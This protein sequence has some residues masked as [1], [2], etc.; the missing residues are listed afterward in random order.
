MPG[1]LPMN[2]VRAIVEH[3]DRHASYSEINR[4]TGASKG[5]ISK[6]AAAVEAASLT[7]EK[8]LLLNDEDIQNRITPG[9]P[10]RQ[11]EPDWALI[12]GQMHSNRHLTLQLMW[13]AHRQSAGDAAYS[14]PSFCR[15]YASWRKDNAPAEG[16]TNLVHAPADV[17]EIDFAGD[18]LL[19]VDSY[20]EMHK[21]RV[22]VA[23]LPYSG[24]IFAQVFEDEKQHSWI[25]GIAEALT[26]FGG[27]PNALLMDNAR[28]LVSRVDKVAGI[29]QPGIEAECGYYGMKPDNCRIH[30]PRDKNRVEA[31][32][33]FVERWI[34]GALEMTGNGAVLAGSRDCLKSMFRK[35]LDECNDRPWT[36]PGRRGSRRSDF[37]EKERPF[38][39]PLPP[40][41]YRMGEWKVYTVDKGHCVRLGRKDGGHRYSVPAAYAGKKVHVLLS[42][43]FVEIFAFETNELIARHVRR[44]DDSIRTHILEEHL[45]PEE[46]ASRRKPEDWINS[47]QQG[48]ISEA[49]ARKFVMSSVRQHGAFPTNR[50]CAAVHRLRKLYPPSVIE[51]GMARLNDA[52][53]WKARILK[54]VCDKIELENRT[55][56]GTQQNGETGSCETTRHENIRNDYE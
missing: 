42:E 43:Q 3:L 52:G 6:V 13:E 44:R 19:W 49:I 16:Y 26:Y 27:V 47:F 12:A 45:T 20:G 48:G 10:K 28:A 41:P 22:F 36:G 1:R 23:T 37:E 50:L 39:K 51:R 46:R 55:A 11:I 56:P 38:L 4:A 24:I 53:T 2:I 8:F 18:P 21:D 7:P 40:A 15:L 31:S 14:Y 5:F 17:M 34:I 32:V 54:S 35:K 33:C 30:S 9:R 29:I 25:E